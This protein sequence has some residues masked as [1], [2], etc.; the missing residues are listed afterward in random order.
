M[1]DCERLRIAIARASHLA[2][3]I[4]A[5]REEPEDTISRILD[6]VKAALGCDVA[7]IALVEPSRA[8]LA[9]MDSTEPAARSLRLHLRGITASIAGWNRGEVVPD[10]ATDPRRDDLVEKSGIRHAVFVPVRVKG[11]PR[12][13]LVAGSR[14][15]GARPTDASDLTVLGLFA[16][17][18]AI[19]LAQIDD[20]REEQVFHERLSLLAARSFDRWTGDEL[21]PALQAVAQERGIA[22]DGAGCDPVLP[23]IGRALD[24]RAVAISAAD[25]SG[26]WRIVES[27]GLPDP[28]A[29]EW[30]EDADEVRRLHRDGRFSCVAAARGFGALDQDLRV[31]IRT[32]DGARILHVLAP[33]KRGAFRPSDVRCAEMAAVRL[34]WAAHAISTEAEL[35]EARRAA[36]AAAEMVLEEI[37]PAAIQVTEAPSELDALLPSSWA[38]A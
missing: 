21:D 14:A 31:L 8:A 38:A 12:G 35:R 19:A 5:R 11:S 16:D 29:K 36:P 1:N 33:A 30:T 32:R 20:R 24:A 28:I 7:A 4:A 22:L 2:A 3:A 26:T 17:V 25:A 10:A 37:E 6:A 27:W 18:A 15:P 34:G 23:E 9:V 13:T